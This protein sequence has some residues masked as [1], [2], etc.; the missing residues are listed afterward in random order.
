[1]RKHTDPHQPEAEQHDTPEV[2]DN[3]MGP[4]Y[5]KTTWGSGDQPTTT[6]P[7]TPIPPAGGGD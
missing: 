3:N 5:D 6:Q 1:M 7:P 2:D 4:E